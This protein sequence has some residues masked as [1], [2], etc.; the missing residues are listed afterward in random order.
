[1]K[2]MQNAERIVGR[3]Q[4]LDCLSKD[5]ELENNTLSVHMSRLR[6]KIGNEYIE[7]IRGFGYRFVGK[8]YK[9]IYE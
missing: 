6:S 1:L 9:D 2:L 4:L 3:E 7:T 5:E 8:V